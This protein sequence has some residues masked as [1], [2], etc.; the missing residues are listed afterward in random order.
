M[1]VRLIQT[2]RDYV[3]ALSEIRRLWNAKAGTPRAAKLELLAMLAHRYEREREPLPALDPIEAIRFRMEQ[4]GLTRKDLV[5]IFGT[6]G[7]VSEVLSGRRALSL[8][9]IRRLHYKLGIPLEALIPQKP[10]RPKRNRASK[11]TAA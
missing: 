10:V 2:E 6:T 11:R 3:A 1:Q 5:P 8:E 4:Q 9:M 7:R